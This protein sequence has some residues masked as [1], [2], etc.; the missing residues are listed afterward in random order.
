MKSPN[1]GKQPYYPTPTKIFAPNLD[2]RSDN[3]CIVGNMQIS[4]QTSTATRNVERD[5]WQT[6]YDRDH[7]GLGPANPM[8]LDNLADKEFRKTTQGTGKD[9]DQIVS[10]RHLDA[11]GIVRDNTASLRCFTSVNIAFFVRLFS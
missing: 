7:T 9:E 4:A 11:M 1:G 10:G 5:Q 8:A 6:T 2:Q 3:R